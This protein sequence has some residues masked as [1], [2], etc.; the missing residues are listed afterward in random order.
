M[1]ENATMDFPVYEIVDSTDEATPKAELPTKPGSDPP[2]I[3]RSSRNVGPPKFYG[4]K[5]SID[6][7]DLP[8]V[9]ICLASNPI[10]LENYNSGKRDTNNRET[11]LEIVTIESDPS[12]PD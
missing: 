12:S 8:Q 4:K 10:L 6:V 7:V 2:I 3:R 9:T 5:Y 11:S 1:G